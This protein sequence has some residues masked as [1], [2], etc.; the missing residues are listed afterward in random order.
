MAR[1]K[2][3]EAVVG[4]V[5]KNKG[6]GC[7]AKVILLNGDAYSQGTTTKA[8]NEMAGVFNEEGIETSMIQ[9]GNQ[10]IRGCTDCG[11]CKESGICVFTDDSVNATA[12][13]F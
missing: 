6:S 7:M 4:L 10:A 9:I 13:E 1:S 3:D 5:C 2:H 8:L 12:A 11:I